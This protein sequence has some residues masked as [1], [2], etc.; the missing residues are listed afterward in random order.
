M[1]PPRV[2]ATLAL[3]ALLLA[4]AGCDKLFSP[5]K[6]PFHGVDVTGLD[7]GSALRLPDFD[8]NLRSLADF[9]GKLVI[10][11]FGYTQCPDV[12]PTTLH[13]YA[14]ALKALGADAS[15]VQFLF[16][17]VDPR[18]DTPKL[19]KEYVPAFDPRFIALRGDAEA[20]A[21]VTKDF[22]VYAEERPGK[23]PES[24]TVDHSS[25]VFVFDRQGRLRLMIP[26]GTAPADIASDLRVLLDN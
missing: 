6:T 13:D 22:K 23:T 14:Q 26:A 7:A 24:Y 25:Q 8:G 3:A 2:L 4:L 17:T 20:T 16:V 19:L 1:K 15:Q 5:P 9:R 12:C 21:R 11:D 10:V 18:R